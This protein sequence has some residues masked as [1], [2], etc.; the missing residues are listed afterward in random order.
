MVTL[1]TTMAT[2]GRVEEGRDLIEGFLA[3][4]GPEVDRVLRARALAALGNWYAIEG[5]R[6]EAEPLFAEALA[7]LEHA[8]ALPVL[9]E[10]MARR[11]LHLEVQARPEESMALVR[12]A[13]ALAE[14]QGAV[15]VAVRATFQLAANLIAYDRQKEALGEIERGLALAR[16]RGDR[17][18]ERMM[19]AERSHCLAFVGRWDEA[20]AAAP[21][22]L[23]SEQD[24]PTN[25]TLPEI[26]AV[27]AGRGDPALLERCLAFASKNRNLPDPEF[28]SMALI[29]LAREALERRQY[30]EVAAF[31]TEVLELQGP[32][33]E[34]ATAAYTLATDAALMTADEQTMATLIA[35]IEAL[36]PVRATPVRLAQR[37][38]LLAE[39]AHRRGDSRAAESCEHE[40]REL[41]RTIGARPLLAGA[42]LDQVRRRGEPE[43]LA[44]T[45]AIYRELGAARWLE[46][47]EAQ[48]GVLA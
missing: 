28:R 13:R 37:A 38:R 48:A 26:V 6:H 8:R 12:H 34:V 33:A 20:I 30:D 27:A 29:A 21:E 15:A 46:L 7:T 22:L 5:S 4:E 40:A 24:A 35:Q 23:I 31:A 43:A 9:A 47:L 14:S 18:W 36:P 45:R 2:A 41:L 17:V 42:L 3:S 19:L 16:E 39:Q 44:E 32:S 1:A 25:Y 10:A 11:A